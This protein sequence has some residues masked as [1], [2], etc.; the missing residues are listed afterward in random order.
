MGVWTTIRVLGIAHLFLMFAPVFPPFEVTYESL[1]FHKRAFDGPLTPNDIL[2]QAEIL[3]TA[4]I[5]S[6][7][8]FF[9]VC[10]LFRFI[11][12]TSE[13]Y[14]YPLGTGIFVGQR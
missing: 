6:E 10:F 3:T 11:R 14:F 2:D 1:T 12:Q 13:S 7:L 4:V 5:G 8:G 9:K